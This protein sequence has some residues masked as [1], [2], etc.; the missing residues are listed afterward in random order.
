MAGLDGYT[1]ATRVKLEG[2]TDSILQLLSQRIATK[3]G[4]IEALEKTIARL[5]NKRVLHQKKRRLSTLKY[6]LKQLETTQK[7]KKVSLCFG[8]KKLFRAQFEREANG[9]A[10]HEDW[11]ND[12]RKT[13]ASEIFIL[14]SKD[15]TSGNQ[16]CTATIAQDGSIHLRIRLPDALI[17]QYGKYLQ[18]PNVRF[19][20]GHDVIAAAI[21]DCC[22]RQQLFLLKDPIYKNHGQAITYRFKKDATR[23]FLFP[24]ALCLCLCIDHLSPQKSRTIERSSS[25]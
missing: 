7:D 19:A 9:Y 17:P 10:S 14:G 12:W 5:K 24:N 6:Q 15:E 20:Y 16:S 22:L 4:Q 23:S 18:I 3:Q 25:S 2:K 11:K 13:R 1:P 8:S 21:R